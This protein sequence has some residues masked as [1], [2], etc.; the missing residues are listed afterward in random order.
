METAAWRRLKMTS[1]EHGLKVGRIRTLP[2]VL[3][4][5]NPWQTPASMPE[6]DFIYCPSTDLILTR[7]ANFEVQE[8][9]SSPFT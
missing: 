8:F 9:V 3:S 4:R 7:V 6:N 5:R 2:C 1:L